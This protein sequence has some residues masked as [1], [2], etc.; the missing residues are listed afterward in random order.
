MVQR[1]ASSLTPK[2]Q[3]H[4]KSTCDGYELIAQAIKEGQLDPSEVL[5]RC[6]QELKTEMTRNMQLSARVVELVEKKEPQDQSS[7]QLAMLRRQTQ[8][9]LTRN[10]GLHENPIPRLFVVLPL[11]H[12]PLYDP[13]NPSSNTFRLYFLCDCG[14]HTMSAKSKTSHHIHFAKHE[15]Y[16]IACP[17]EFFRRYG[18]YVLTILRMLKF[19]ISV[20]GI[21][22]PALSRLVRMS[23]DG[24]ATADQQLL[25]GTIDSVMGLTM[26]YIEKISE[27][28]VE[29]AGS[30]E[31]PQGLDLCRLETFLKKKDN[32]NVLGNLYRIATTEGHVKWVCIDHYRERHQANS[33][34]AFRDAVEV[35]QGSYDENYG[36]AE[37]QLCSRHEADMFTLALAKVKALYELKICLSWEST[38]RDF[39]R[40]RDS[41]VK[42][43]VGVLEL[44]LQYQESPDSDSLYL[45]KRYDPIFDIMRHSTIQSVTLL[46][47][48]V[49]FIKLSSLLSSNELFNN[50]KHLNVGISSA[51]DSDI[52]GYKNLVSKAPNLSSL[53]VDI[54]EPHMLPFYNAIAEHQTYPINFVNPLLRILPPTRKPLHPT[55]PLLDFAGLLQVHGG[56]VEIVQLSEGELNEPTLAAFAKATKNGSRLKE[57]V[58]YGV[59]RNLG[60][61]CIDDLAS[62]AA[63][64]ELYN[65]DIHLDSEEERVYILESV[66]WKYIR[67]L[68]VGVDDESVGMSPLKA[69]VDGIEELSGSV[70]LEHFVFS[71]EHPGDSLPI[72]QQQLLQSLLASTS[73]KH[74]KLNVTLTLEQMLSLIESANVSRLQQ[75]ILLGEG[76]ESSDVDAILDKLQHAADLRN[77]CLTGS[78]IKDEQIER[79]ETRGITLERCE[80]LYCV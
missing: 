30:D 59:D 21:T 57:L 33:R 39:K 71:Y 41:L 14:E 4:L 13:Q 69:I 65:L 19:G 45:S 2:I 51:N 75:L 46:Q 54:D 68:M 16:D 78:N 53:A 60:E 38:H 61:Q 22:V 80:E 18:S 76:F 23:D 62:I 1:L 29:D 20:G 11:V 3:A 73:L 44:D 7:D 77:L 48:P 79:M 15:G 6:F 35:L 36:R 26:E 74:L 34:K 66:Q 28:E 8:S 32:E 52:P 25:A 58:L 56:R 17:D 63:R 70:I 12:Q 10:I 50:L 72:A 40:L 64:S 49:D 47:L 5:R 55:T 9:V 37:V 67:K 27:R 43:N 31:A 24:Q 42:S